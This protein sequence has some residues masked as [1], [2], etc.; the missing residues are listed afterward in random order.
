MKRR[1]AT[2]VLAFTVAG[3]LASVVAG[4]LLTR[5]VQAT[6]GEAPRGL[7]AEA[8]RVAYG[9]DQHLA[10]WFLP[11]QPGHGAVLLLHG[12]RG[13]RLQMLARARWLQQAGVASLL[14]DLPAH[15]ESSGERIGFGR[16]EAPAVDAALAWLRG[17]LPQ[18][19]IGAIGASLGGASL[20][21][22]KRQ[23]ELDALVIESVYPTIDE[24][25]HNRLAQRLGNFPAQALAP[26]L[27][28]QIP[29]RLGLRADE[30]RPVDAIRTLAAP[31]LVASGADDAHTPWPETERL[32]AAARMPKVVWR[33]DGAAHV[34]LHAF[35]PEAYQA[36]IGAWLLP[37][38]RRDTLTRP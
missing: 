7:N 8:V 32:Y 10:A 6:V 35:A 3:A 18:E 34:D 12:V 31:V 28:A 26:L 36:R 17:R 38:L 15:G 24:A 1:L 4:D 22:A 27:L 14:V 29:W 9:D 19:R 23:P 11:G 21:F 37:H 25:V 16:L 2:G 5:P 20:L 13:S 30:L 33:V